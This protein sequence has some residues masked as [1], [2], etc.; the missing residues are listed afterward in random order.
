MILSA[1]KLLL[2]VYAQEWPPLMSLEWKESRFNPTAQLCYSLVCHISG[3]EQDSHASFC[4]VSG[5]SFTIKLE[6]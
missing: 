6:V 5:N 2:Q 3:T 1:T 4:H